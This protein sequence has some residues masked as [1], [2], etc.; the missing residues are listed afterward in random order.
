M[1]IRPPNYRYAGA[2]GYCSLYVKDEGYCLVDLKSSKVI[3]NFTE[4]LQ[5]VLT[6]YLVESV[7][8]F[9]YFS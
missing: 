2:T 5:L 6:F 8:V 3:S 9:C 1:N 7:M 4:S